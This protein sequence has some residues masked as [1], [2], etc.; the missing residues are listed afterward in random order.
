MHGCVAHFCFRTFNLRIS[1]VDD[2]G[3]LEKRETLIVQPA[4][5]YRTGAEE[6]EEE[7]E[8]E[9]ARQRECT[10]TG[11][12]GLC[13]N[14]RS[15]R[16]SRWG[17]IWRA[18]RWWWMLAPLAMPR[19]RTRRRGKGWSLLAV[20][21]TRGCERQTRRRVGSIGVHAEQSKM[22]A[23]YR[24][25]RR[26][27]SRASDRTRWWCRPTAGHPNRVRRYLRESGA[28]VA[29]QLLVTA[30]RWL[31]SSE[32]RHSLDRHVACKLNDILR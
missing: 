30:G 23:E 19:S 13:A 18:A 11:R 6:E 21:T 9:E 2:D 25:K 16:M 3:S 7:E 32:N 27:R 4:G 15:I 31:A 12:R 8:E 28:S 1:K 22:R 17:W 20:R 10:N 24:E 29:R 5:P 26:G 14:I